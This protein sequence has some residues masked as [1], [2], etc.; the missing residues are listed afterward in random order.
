MTTHNCQYIYN[1]SCYALQRVHGLSLEMS[2]TVYFNPIHIPFP[3]QSHRLF[4]FPPTANPMPSILSHL[5]L[6]L[7]T[8][9]TNNH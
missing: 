9:W 8:P 3:S 7:W 2:G 1:Y 6:F 5:L 4:P